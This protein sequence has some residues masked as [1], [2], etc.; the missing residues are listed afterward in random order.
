MRRYALTSALAGLCLLLLIN[1]WF[2]LD[3]GIKQY[4]IKSRLHLD[5]INSSAYGEKDLV[6]REGAKTLV[7]I[8]GDSRAAQ[9]PTNKMSDRFQ[10][11][12]RGVAGQTTAQ[13][14]LRFP[15]DVIDLQPEVVLVQAGINDLKTI[16]L[17][18][19]QADA[20]VEGCKANLEA[21][22]ELALAQGI[23]LILMPVLPTG[24]VPFSRR[25]FWSDQIDAA[26]D[27]VN[28]YI[29]ELSQ[30]ENV[31]FFDPVTLIVDSDGLVAP[32]YRLDFLHLNGRAYELLG[33]QLEEFLMELTE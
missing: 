2:L 18:P 21:L 11:V 4:K 8:F 24:P 14:L 26:I 33:Q 16:G 27:N 28:A 20:I 3:Y 29:L 5:P 7:T 31:E 6:V 32:A 12:N 15:E 1:C 19:Q 10:F 17:F 13:L 9:W 30:R 25:F 23:T 22:T